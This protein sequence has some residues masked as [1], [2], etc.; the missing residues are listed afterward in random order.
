MPLAIRK[1]TQENIAALE[2]A[3]RPALVEFSANWCVYCRR[4]E[5]ALKRLSEKYAGKVDFGCV[6][7]DDDPALEERFDVETVPSLFVYVASSWS[8]ALV[9]PSSEAE[10][11]AFL[12]AYIEVNV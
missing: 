7:I 6:N 10:I 4:I 2:A 12:R 3:D 1:I 5:P 11:E 9:A 8:E